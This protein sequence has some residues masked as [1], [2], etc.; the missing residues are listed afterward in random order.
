[1]PDVFEETYR[2]Y[3]DRLFSYVLTIVERAAIAEDV[4]QEVF[5]AYFAKAPALR[6]EGALKSFLYA[7]AHNRAIDH[8]RRRSSRPLPDDDSL[9]A[10][11]PP[12]LAEDDCAFIRRC[13]RSLKPDQR[14]VVFLK[15]YEDMT[16]DEIARILGKPPGTIAARYR[17]AL[18]QLRAALEPV[19]EV[20]P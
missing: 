10:S 15:V 3:K 19:W 6:V 11:A 4:V 7:C 9:V 16:L 14:E 8:L 18:E 2:R 1:M 17:H 20:H 13:V 12:S 5:G